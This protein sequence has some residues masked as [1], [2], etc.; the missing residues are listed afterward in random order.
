MNYGEVDWRPKREETEESTS[1]II[2][3]TI[4]RKKGVISRV[5]LKLTGS[6]S[7]KAR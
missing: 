1:A 6:G 3:I 5:Y 2:Q 7:I 4:V